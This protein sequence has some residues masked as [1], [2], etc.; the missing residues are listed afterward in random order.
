VNSKTIVPWVILATCLLGCGSQVRGSGVSKTEIRELA[1]FNH[2]TLHGAHGEGT[3]HISIGTPQLVE[4][5]T[6]DNLLPL[7]ETQ[8]EDGRLVIRPK[9]AI[10][11]KARLVVK[12]RAARLHGV[13]LAGGATAEVAD[14]TGK[15]FDVAITGGGTMTV[16]G[17]TELLSVKVE[18]NGEVK[19][20]GLQA[21]NARV[22]IVGGGEVAVQA[23]EELAGP[24]RVDIDIRG[25]GTTTV[26]GRVEGLA[27]R[28][29]GYG[30][31]KA[32]DLEVSNAKVRIIGAGDVALHAKEE[33]DVSIQGSG[34]VRYKGD[35]KVTKDIPEG[36]SLVRIE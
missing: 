32:A 13:A 6:D 22:S 23:T 25:N 19:A 36:G 2:V 8:I 35:P 30:V 9:Q 18:G 7:I 28:I 10:R 21:S 27:V 11:P 5:A 12:I 29:E 16:A 3:A 33:L 4:I 24:D 1:G 26:A 31:V 15:G 20:T 17:R 34:S 14:V